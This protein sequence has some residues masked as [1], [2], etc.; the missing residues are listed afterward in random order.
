MVVDAISR[1][2]SSTTLESKLGASCPIKPG[3]ATPEGQ[4]LS[5]DSFTDFFL[6]FPTV[7]AAS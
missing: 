6:S 3:D 4:F 2:N 1:V 5:F 7:N